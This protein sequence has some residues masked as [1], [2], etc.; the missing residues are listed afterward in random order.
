MDWL[1]GLVNTACRTR[2]AE[3]LELDVKKRIGFAVVM[4]VGVALG[5]CARSYIQLHNYNSADYG[6]LLQHRATF[7]DA[8]FVGL[9]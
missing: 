4:F 3:S 2:R 6:Q 8:C 7:A 9:R 1:V 5:W